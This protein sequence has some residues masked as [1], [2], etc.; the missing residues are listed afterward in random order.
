M[1][2]S[3]EA[4]QEAVLEGMLDKVQDKWKVVEFTLN[5]FK[6]AKDTFVLAGIDDVLQV[7]EESLVAM[8]IITASRYAAGIRQVL[9]PTI[10]CH[11]SR[12]KR[13]RVELSATTMA[14]LNL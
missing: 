6:D 2:V 5:P 1:T 3:T 9:H 4:T 12:Y 10:F 13:C 14:V 7:L 8:A 11:V